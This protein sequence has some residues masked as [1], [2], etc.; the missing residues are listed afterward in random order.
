MQDAE[1]TAMGIERITEILDHRWPQAEIL[2]LGLFPRGEDP[3]D[4]KRKLN[5][6]IN[7]RIAEL[8]GVRRIT[9]LDIGST[10]LQDDGTISSNVMPDFLHLSPH[11][12]RLWAEAMAGK[13]D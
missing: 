7:S 4:P 5:Q 1:E 3:E 8:D 6:A 12:Y 2:L 11:G 9:S 13:M 10:F